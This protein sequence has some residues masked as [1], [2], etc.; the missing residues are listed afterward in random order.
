MLQVQWCR[1]SCPENLLFATE[2]IFPTTMKF[3]KS[4]SERCNGAKSKQGLALHVVK[5]NCG[6]FGGYMLQWRHMSTN[7]LR[8]LL[9]QNSIW[10]CSSLCMDNFCCISLQANPKRGI[11]TTCK[12]I[13]ATQNILGHRPGRWGDEPWGSTPNTTE[14]DQI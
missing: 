4:G 9:H 2:H 7:R 14:A 8:G 5:L 10:G 3:R 11:P 12:M 6:P 13:R 1:V